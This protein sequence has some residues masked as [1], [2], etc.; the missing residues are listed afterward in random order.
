MNWEMPLLLGF[1]IILG[2][3][4]GTPDIDHNFVTDENGLRHYTLIPEY[5]HLDNPYNDLTTVSL[6][7]YENAWNVLD[8]FA[9]HKD[10]SDTITEDYQ[11]FSHS[12][13][14]FGVLSAMIGI[15]VLTRFA[16]CF[17]PNLDLR[18]MP[19]ILRTRLE[20]LERK[21]NLCC[22]NYYKSH[23]MILFWRI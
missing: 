7:R 8:E 22:I 11:H 13:L 3:V 16:K 17:W 21:T 5:T 14:L 12:F 9:A 6:L 18:Y 23:N 19:I 1:I 15:M 2:G 10:S 20:W 4:A